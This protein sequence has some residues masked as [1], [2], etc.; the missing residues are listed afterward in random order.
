MMVMMITNTTTTIIIIYII[1]LFL[2]TEFLALYFEM[3]DVNFPL[4][5]I[6]T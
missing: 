5:I 1:L 2:A 4:Y 6:R 3:K